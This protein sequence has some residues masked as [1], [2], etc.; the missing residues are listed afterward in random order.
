MVYAQ[1]RCTYRAF[2]RPPLLCSVLINL[3]RQGPHYVA[4]AGLKLLAS[5]YPPSLASQK[6]EIIGTSPRLECNGAISAHCNL[7]LPGSNNSPSSVSRVAGI[8]GTCHHS[9]LIFVFL[10]ETGFHHA[11]QAG[12]ELPTSGDPPTSPSQIARITGMSHHAWPHISLLKLWG[13]LYDFSE[14]CRNHSEALRDA[15][16]VV[17]HDAEEEDQDAGHQDDS[18]H[19]RPGGAF[20]HT[21]PVLLLLHRLLGSPALQR[22][23]FGR[24]GHHGDRLLLAPGQQAAA[25]VSGQQRALLGDGQGQH[26]A[27]IAGK[28]DEDRG[29]FRS[30]WDGNDSQDLRVVGEL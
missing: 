28:F 14:S 1:A 11:G 21:P 13:L 29:V 30:V 22:L 20:H 16:H 23:L 4:Q 10:I 2:P 15:R 6:A 3:Q 7:H 27:P 8:T 19:P 9:R 17:E 12:L 24:D 18:A 5:S 26:V 25:H